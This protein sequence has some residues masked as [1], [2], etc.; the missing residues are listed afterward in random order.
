[1]SVCLELFNCEP[2]NHLW[3]D[4]IEKFGIMKATQLVRQALDLQ[5][6]QS[7]DG[8]LPVLFVKT[9]G[10]ALTSFELLE[11]QTGL[12]LNGEDKVLLYSQKDKIFQILHEVKVPLN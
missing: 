7:K 5:N 6:M 9:G 1:M 3:T 12:K 4:L 2:V 11:V 10:V 8:V